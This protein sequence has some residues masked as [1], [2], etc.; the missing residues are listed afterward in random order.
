MA[1]LVG[2]LANLEIQFRILLK[3]KRNAAD[4]MIKICGERIELLDRL[5]YY[6]YIKLL[7]AIEAAKD[8]VRSLNSQRR[9]LEKQ[10]K[11]MKD[12][13]KKT[14]LAAQLNWTE[15]RLRKMRANMS[16]LERHIQKSAQAS[17]RQKQVAVRGSSGI[18][19]FFIMT[20]RGSDKHLC[21]VMIARIKAL[22]KAEEMSLNNKLSFEQR[23]D[24]TIKR[25]D[26]LEAFEDDLYFKEL[27][28]IKDTNKFI[29]PV[30]QAYQARAAQ[31][32]AASGQQARDVNRSKIMKFVK[33]LQTEHNGLIERI[34]NFCGEGIKQKH[35]VARRI[36]GLAMAT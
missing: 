30:I 31:E 13:A 22:R 3:D 33:D 15:T 20:F 16:K 12:P 19:D 8:N 14:Q 36:N 23:L 1:K 7:R 25:I 11:K 17:M 2:N 29:V 26:V 6:A 10:M 24:W 18:K 9:N 32:V 28:V 21:K 35:I 4:E 27:R 5:E 34:R